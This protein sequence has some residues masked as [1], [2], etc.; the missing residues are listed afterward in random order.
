MQFWR[1]FC[2]NQG[3]AHLK[4]VNYSLLLSSDTSLHT[5]VKKDIDRT[6]P[7]MQYF[8]KG[9]PG[10]TKLFNVL[11]AVAKTFPKIGY[12]QGMNFVAAVIVINLS[13]EEVCNLLGLLLDDVLSPQRKRLQEAIQPFSKCYAPRIL[14]AELLD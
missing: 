10:Y 7:T 2:I 11:T 4:G 13:K 8:D 3:K 9:K 6:F 12:C 5:L 14:S 1:H